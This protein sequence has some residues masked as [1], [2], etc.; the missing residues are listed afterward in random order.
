MEAV[1]L[2]ALNKET[3]EDVLRHGAK[4]IL[5]TGCLLIPKELYEKVMEELTDWNMAIE[6][7]RRLKDPN[8]KY[9]TEQEAMK[10]LGLTEKDLEGWEDVEIE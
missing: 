3:F 7:D 2:E 8:A 6:A 10:A 9:Y 4:E 5:G 1:T